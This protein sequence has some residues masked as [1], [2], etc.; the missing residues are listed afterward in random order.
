MKIE[1]ILWPTD[2]SENAAIAM[3]FV[4]S[5]SEKYQAEVHV[6]Y[7]IEAMGPFGA[8]YGDFE[9]SHAEKEKIQEMEREAAE[10]ELET[11]CSK[12]LQGCPLYVRHIAVGEPAGEILKAVEREKMDLVVMAS[13]GRRGRFLFGSVTERVVKHCTVPVLTVP[14]GDRPTH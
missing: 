3:P 11:I 4:Q 5:L 6:L 10:R 14:V 9:R 2:V 8:W 13:R 7:V 1:K 12:N